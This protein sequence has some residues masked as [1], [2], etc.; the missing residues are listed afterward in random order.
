MSCIHTDN[1]KNLSYLISLGA[2][3]L[4]LAASTATAGSWSVRVGATYLQTVDESDAF[5]ALGMN[6][7][8]DAL[9]V[10]DRTIPE[11]DVSYAFTEK[12]SAELVLTIPQK[13]HVNLAGV[14]RLG[15]FKHLPPTLLLQYRPLTGK[16][17]PY[18]AAGVNFTLIFDDELSVA[19]VPLK[20]ENSSVG[21]AGQVG[22][23]YDLNERWSFNANVKKAVLRSDV[24]AGGAALTEARLDP[25]LYAVGFVRKF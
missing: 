13:H 6:F 12:L 9:S 14:G 4:G 22:F 16:F 1:M 24:L 2:V 7:A 15:S 18:F 20:L 5:S 23:D 19:G 17:R 25:W 3:T 11:I 8:E 21:L 10:S